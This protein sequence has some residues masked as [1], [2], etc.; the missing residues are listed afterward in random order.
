MRL[1]RARHTEH[2]RQLPRFVAFLDAAGLPTVT[3]AAA[4]A[5]A[6]GPDVDPASSMAPRRMTI[7]RGFARYLAG[8][9]DRTEVPP[10]GLIAGRRRWRPP[11]I[12]SPADIAA[13]MAQARC[14]HHPLPAATYETVIGLLAATGLRIG[15][16][17][18]LDRT[19]IDRDDA[20][21]TIRK[22]KFGKTRIVPMLESTL[23]ALDDYARTRDQLCPHPAT[24]SYGS[25]GPQPRRE[26]F[27]RTV[28]SDVAGRPSTAIQVAHGREF[29]P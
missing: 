4:L 5:W 27:R 29:S 18:R 17:I 26:A 28:M 14:L 24:T 3:V 9:D 6:Q 16:A 22:S 20:V 25:S 7:A 11:F 21:L 1:V 8:L 10:P 23:P 2:H 13:L 12:Y 19:D 15:E